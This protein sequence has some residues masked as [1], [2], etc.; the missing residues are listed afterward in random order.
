M[1][2]RPQGK[3]GAA[4]NAQAECLCHTRYTASAPWATS[5]D[6]PLKTRGG[7]PEK[8][9]GRLEAGATK[10]L[11]SLRSPAERQRRDALSHRHIPPTQKPRKG[12]GTRAGPHGPET[13]KA[14]AKT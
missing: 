13:R 12:V 14:T 6:P 1:T 7:A 5:Q 4:K 10:K 2:Q 9:G 3:G 11:K 8:A